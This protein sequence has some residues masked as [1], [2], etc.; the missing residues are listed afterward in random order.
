MN[1]KFTLKLKDA[2]V[3]GEKM[4]EFI[5]EWTAKAEPDEVL[6][7]SREWLSSRDEVAQKLVNLSHVG[8][9][10]LAMDAA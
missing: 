9:L 4:D 8:E 1:V 10:S 7:I 3:N 2:V 6:Q 5:I